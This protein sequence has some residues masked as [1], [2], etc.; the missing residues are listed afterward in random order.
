MA[1]EDLFAQFFGGGGAFG[2]MFGGGGGMRGE[3]AVKKARTI[4]HVHKVS[5]EDIYKGKVSKLVGQK[6][7][8]LQ[9]NHSQRT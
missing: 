5:L 7:P 9:L 1:A 8:L 4:S 6:S 2:G 3:P